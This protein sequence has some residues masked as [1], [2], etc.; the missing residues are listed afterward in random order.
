MAIEDVHVLS[1]LC[2]RQVTWEISGFYNMQ[3]VVYSVYIYIFIYSFMHLSMYFNLFVYIYIYAVKL[4]ISIYILYVCL[5]NMSWCPNEMWWWRDY[6]LWIPCNLTMALYWLVADLLNR[7]RLFHGE[8]K[9][10]VYE[11]YTVTITDFPTRVPIL[12]SHRLIEPPCSCLL[13]W[14]P[15]KATMLYILVNFPVN[16]HRL[17]SLTSSLVLQIPSFGRRSDPDFHQP[18]T[19]PRMVSTGPHLFII[20]FCRHLPWSSWIRRKQNDRGKKHKRRIK[21]F[22]EKTREIH[23]FKNV[24]WKLREEVIAIPPCVEDR[25]DF[26]KQCSSIFLPFSGQHPFFVLFPRIES[27]KWGA[28]WNFTEIK[29]TCSGCIA[30]YIV[31]V[32]QNVCRNMTP[33]QGGKVGNGCHIRQQPFN[34]PCSVGTA[35]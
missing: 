15:P 12:D 1:L 31:V 17:T 26:N 10:R 27:A 16:F 34:N 14:Y 33:I 28:H 32:P 20:L 13:Q 29:A 2:L 3:I 21:K 24:Q 22:T 11:E 23:G 30:V 35:D 8:G 18:P 25:R 19:F 7:S 9:T 4:L 5:N 6:T